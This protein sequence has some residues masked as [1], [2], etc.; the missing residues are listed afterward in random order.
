MGELKQ[1]LVA[2]HKLSQFLNGQSVGLSIR[3]IAWIF[4]AFTVEKLKIYW[5][6]EFW[7]RIQIF[8]FLLRS[9]SLWSSGTSRVRGTYLFMGRYLARCRPKAFAIFVVLLGIVKRVF[10]GH[11][12]WMF[13]CGYGH[14]VSSISLWGRGLGRCRE[15][16]YM[17]WLCGA[18]SCR[19]SLLERVSLS[20]QFSACTR[21]ASRSSFCPGEVYSL[22]TAF[23]VRERTEKRAYEWKLRFT[24]GSHFDVSFFIAWGR[25]GTVLFLCFLKVSRYRFMQWQE[26][27]KKNHLKILLCL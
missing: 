8:L 12:V 25:A 13:C 4:V 24:K 15:S 21:R 23:Q 20:L 18:C 16:P 6:D 7:C 22:L 19:V 27:K 11:C 5:N 26:K 9:P 1:R 17:C 14:G 3:F 2:A 10:L